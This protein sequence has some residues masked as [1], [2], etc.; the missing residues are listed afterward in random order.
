MYFFMLCLISLWISSRQFEALRRPKVNRVKEVL[1]CL[2]VFMSFVGAN[3]GLVLFVSELDIGVDVT[4]QR[5]FT[6]NTQ[7]KDIAENLPKITNIQLFFNESLADVPP[8]IRDHHKRVGKLLKRIEKLSKGRVEVEFV[9]LSEDTE[10]AELAEMSGISAV[11][12]QP[13]SLFG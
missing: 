7:T 3:A 11:P 6:L 1:L 12:Q 4:E 5:E 10:L 2:A 13:S 8:T 9:A